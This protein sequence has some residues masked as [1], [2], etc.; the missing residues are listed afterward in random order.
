MN[1]GIGYYT[2]AILS[3]FVAAASAAIVALQ[4]GVDGSHISFGEWVVIATAFVISGAAVWAVPNVPESVR[5]Y[6][7]AITAGLTSGLSA[8]GA[9]L[10]DGSISAHEWIALL[11]ALVVGSGLV[12]I[13]PN[14]S[15]S[16]N[17]IE[18]EDEDD[19]LLLDEPEEGVD[20]VPGDFDENDT[21]LLPPDPYEQPPGRNAPLQGGR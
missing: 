21:S 14:A 18:Y 20:G 13:A 8:L 1:S 17:L 4:D 6:G 10:T 2:K 9:S 19:V 15:A 7:K 12:G 3:A 11:M 5:V 16:D